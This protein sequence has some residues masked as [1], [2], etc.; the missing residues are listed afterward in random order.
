MTLYPIIKPPP[1]ENN[2]QL[3]T[4]PPK[5]TMQHVPETNPP[6]NKAP[7]TEKPITEGPLPLDCIVSN[8]SSELT[9]IRT[10]AA[11]ENLKLKVDPYYNK[12]QKVISKLMQ[13]KLS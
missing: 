1:P 5:K 12:I 6:Q 4:K 10:E 2:T 13:S 8:L 11:L 9:R 7:S 3:R